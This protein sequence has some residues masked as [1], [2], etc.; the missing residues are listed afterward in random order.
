[1]APGDAST[2]SRSVPLPS[3]CRVTCF[4]ISRRSPAACRSP[5]GS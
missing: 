2:L 4:A 1:L 5:R 3:P